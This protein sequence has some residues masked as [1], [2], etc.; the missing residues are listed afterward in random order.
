[1]VRNSR[2]RRKDAGFM[3]TAP[4]PVM[5][6]QTRPVR[7]RVVRPPARPA[8]N[9]GRG[10]S[11]R[12]TLSS[13][14]RRA[15]KAGAPRRRPRCH[16]CSY[17]TTAPTGCGPGTDAFPPVIPSDLPSPPSKQPPRPRAP[18][19]RSLRQI[20]PQAASWSQVVAQPDAAQASILLSGAWPRSARR[21][22]VS[23]TPRARR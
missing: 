12:A 16:I 9:R 8:W 13:W 7:Q 5:G 19:L 14:C 17:G 18:G 23:K 10:A 15:T 20:P 1:M 11:R 22:S 6:V 4:G 2:S 3:A 21:L